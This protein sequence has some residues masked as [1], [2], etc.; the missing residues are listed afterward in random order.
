MGSRVHPHFGRLLLAIATLAATRMEFLR[1][2][3]GLNESTGLHRPNH[4]CS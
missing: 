1:S 4:R 3:I 2:T